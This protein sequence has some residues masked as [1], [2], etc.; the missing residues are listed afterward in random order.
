[1]TPENETDR[2]EAFAARGTQINN[3]PDWGSG[4]SLGEIKQPDDRI[5]IQV[6]LD[7]RR[8]G[9]VIQ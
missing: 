4:W 9:I 2:S 3:Q 7:F 8:S 5:Q 1:V 6:L